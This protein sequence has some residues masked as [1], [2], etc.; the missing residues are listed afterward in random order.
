MARRTK[1]K[2]RSY[3]FRHARRE[4]DLAT[5]FRKPGSIA[6][7]SKTDSNAGNIQLI[8][9]NLIVTI[10]KTTKTTVVRYCQE[11]PT[12]NPHATHCDSIIADSMYG[13]SVCRTYRQPRP[14]QCSN[15][16]PQINSRG[17]GLQQDVSKAVL[18][19]R[20]SF[21]AL[22]PSSTLAVPLVPYTSRPS[23]G[24]MMVIF[25]L[26]NTHSLDLE[27]LATLFQERLSAILLAMTARYNKGGVQ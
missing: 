5:G 9:E 12:L 15:P 22:L 20:L 7:I 6:E 8:R 10:S 23:S 4:L 14:A 1:H 21:A 24:S 19:S 26:R 25:Q 2:M 18:S 11:S 17:G 16:Q 13:L 27:L 3:F